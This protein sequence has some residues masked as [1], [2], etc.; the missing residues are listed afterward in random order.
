MSDPRHTDPR[1]TDPREPADTPANM[2]APHQLDPASRRGTPGTTWTWVAAIVAIIVVLG[3]VLGYNRTEVAQNRSNT[4]T[5]T[6][7]APALPRSAA[8]PTSGGTATPT[9]ATPAPPVQQSI[10]DPVQGR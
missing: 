1:Y 9:P 5:T 3:L 10:P 6:G 2:N 7:A 8:P 4:P